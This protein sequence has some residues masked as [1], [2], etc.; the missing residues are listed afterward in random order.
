MPDLSKFPMQACASTGGMEIYREPKSLQESDF[1]G[2]DPA[3]LEPDELVLSL[4][5]IS[6]QRREFGRT[7]LQKMVYLT[8]VALRW[9]R[10]DHRAH[11]YGPFSR[12]L[13][14]LTAHL[15]ARDELIEESTSLGFV[16]GGGYPAKRFNYSLTEKGAERV[17]DL[18]DRKPAD[19]AALASFVS[20]VED[21][22]G[23]LD[24]RTLSLAAKVYYIVENHDGP[25]NER[26]IVQSA[27]ELGW[28][29][30]EPQVEKVSKILSHL[31]LVRT[32]DA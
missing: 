14:R 22:V 12:D 16:G 5:D 6:G 4:V 17:S 27:T 19:V 26:K 25:V 15:V 28:A 20:G 9:P 1:N 3:M 21:A 2:D 24:Q 18:R 7:T 8:T 10:L 29:I 30:S 31:E 13:E 23:S 32:V 11:F